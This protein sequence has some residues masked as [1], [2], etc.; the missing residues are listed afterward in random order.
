MEMLA[1]KGNG[2]YSYIDSLLEA[3]KVLVKESLSTL[4]TLA[5]D[6]K[7]QIEFNPALVGAYRLIGY[8]NRVLADEDFTDDTKDAGEIGVG[9]TVTA[10]YEIIPPGS[11]DIPNVPQL[12]YKNTLNFDKKSDKDEILTVSLRYKE[13]SQ[14]TSKLLSQ[15]L[16]ASKGT[17]AETSNDYRF[18]T[19][20]AWFGMH[21][22]KSAFLKEVKFSQ[23]IDRA[24]KSR[25]NDAD[26]LRAEFI[27]LVETAELLENS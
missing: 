12:K 13:P 25:G 8:D 19:A 2:N 1:D 22:Q 24:K 6:V 23:I 27:K 14:S 21:L 26:G 16:A 3:K 5:K 15:P 10:L 17:S 11:T 7:L 4:Y 20:V 18:A 9:H